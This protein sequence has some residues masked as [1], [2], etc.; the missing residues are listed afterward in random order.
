M[1]H[2]GIYQIQMNGNNVHYEDQP[3]ALFHFRLQI[4]NVSTFWLRAICFFP[5]R[6]TPTSV[7]LSF[8]RQGH[9]PH[10]LITRTLICIH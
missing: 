2:S 7:T 4:R 1:T 6:K 9:N 10:N 5:N 3:Q 8:S